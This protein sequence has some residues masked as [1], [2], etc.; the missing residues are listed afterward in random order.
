M[1]HLFTLILLLLFIT[2]LSGQNIYVWDRDLGDIFRDPVTGKWV[3][4]E[5]G[6]KSA[7]SANGYAYNSGTTLPAELINYDLLFVIMGQYC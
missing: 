2:P 6:I 1:R 7:L 3:G 5:E 4:C